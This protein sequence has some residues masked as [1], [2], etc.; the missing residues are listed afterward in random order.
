MQ[1]NVSVLIATIVAVII[2]VLFPIYNIATRQDS[3]ANNMVVRATTNFVDEVR[4]KGYIDKE[5]YGKFLNELDKTGNTY[6][7]EME[8]YKPIL[9]ETV[10]ST[11][12]AKE[13]EENYDVDYTDTIIAGMENSTLFKDEGSVKKSDVYYLYDDYKFYVRV[14]NTNVTQ[15][16]ILL[17]R[18]L[19]GKQN[20][21]IVVN[22]GGVVYSNEWAHG[23]NA[24]SAS[25]NIS[26]SRPLNNNLKEFKYEYIT[27]IYDQTLDE[28]K[29]VYAIA[30]RLSDEG[31][32]AG[33]I[34]FR[35]KYNGVEQLTSESGTVL[36][37][38][39]DRENHIKNYIETEGF[40]VEKQYIQ[41]D[42]ISVKNNGDTYDYEYIITFSNISYNFQ[43]NPYM[44][45]RVK[46]NAGS[47]YTKAG[48][49]SELNSK[50]FVITYELNEPTVVLA[51]TPD[52]I[53]DNVVAPISGGTDITFIVTGQLESDT[54][55]VVKAVIEIT[56]NGTVV[57]NETINLDSNG[58]ATLNYKF[59]EGTGSVSAYVID[60][61]GTQSEK[62]GY[63]FIIMNNYLSASINTRGITE[64]NTVV[65]PNATISAYSFGGAF[66]NHGGSDWW[67]VTGLVKGTT[68]TWEVV[69]PLTGNYIPS[70]Q[71]LRANKATGADFNTGMIEISDPKRY[72]QLKFEYRTDPTHDG[73][74]C[75][76]NATIDYKVDYKF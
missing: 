73:S 58:K 39:V 45:G 22:Y 17:D 63:G 48:Q 52:V 71:T 8:V 47:A 23:E 76:R 25:A 20:E 62:V 34:K 11:S 16:Q 64:M 56:N 61:R 18:L 12:D 1:D 40:V 69:N 42:E 50:Y 31:V 41:V 59:A 43:N 6:D 32:G 33:N 21:R 66:P 27:D 7:V 35:L 72:V 60:S 49:V 14:K 74:S 2:I 26:I 51:S 44:E 38:E 65:I 19:S 57:K 75:L 10:D 53:A 30:V 70:G 55:R 37:T 5:T 15:A 68:D 36:N 29:T 3:I 54:A 13:F 67:R 24:E 28:L 4:N 46:I 9:L